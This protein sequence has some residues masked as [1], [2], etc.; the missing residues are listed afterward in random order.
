MTSDLELTEPFSSA[1]TESMN[2]TFSLDLRR[3]LRSGSPLVLEL[4]VSVFSRVD[5]HE[6]FQLRQTAD[7]LFVQE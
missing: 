6:E 1:E 2:R 5:D 3:V 4:E 7:P